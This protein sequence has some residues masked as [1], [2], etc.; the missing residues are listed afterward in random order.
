M[1]EKRRELVA[2]CDI[3]NGRSNIP[4]DAA[5]DCYADRRI[6]RE[7]VGLCTAM[8]KGVREFSSQ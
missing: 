8:N 5:Y 2:C 6:S 3:H 4:S 1:G 7:Q